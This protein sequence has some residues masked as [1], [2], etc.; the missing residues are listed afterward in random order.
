MMARI[1]SKNTKPEVL[2]RSAV[3]ALGVRFR[4][5][6][7]DLPGKPDLANKSR[8]WAIFVHGCFWHSHADCR[9]ASSPKSNAAYWHEKL[10]R[11]TV[12]DS[13]KIAALRSQGYRVLIVWECDVREG[14]RFKSAL[15]SFFASTT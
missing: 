10:F 5:H 13:E 11:N 7:D 6:V 4:N 3:H 15:K 1:R 14:T 8:K 12:R 9:L 2:T